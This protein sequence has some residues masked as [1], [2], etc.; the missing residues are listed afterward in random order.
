MTSNICDACHKNETGTYC[1]SYNIYKMA[2]CDVCNYRKACGDCS[3]QNKTKTTK[4]KKTVKTVEKTEAA[5][6]RVIH[7]IREELQIIKQRVAALDKEQNELSKKLKEAE[8]I[9][10]QLAEN[11]NKIE[12]LLAIQENLEEC[13][14]ILGK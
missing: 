10:D 14:T 6:V 13:I 9:D 4:K 3:C 2:D 12:D 8:K 5:N 7:A 1:M 11:E